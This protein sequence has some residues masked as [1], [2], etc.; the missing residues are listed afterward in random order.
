MIQLLDRSDLDDVISLG[1]YAFQYKVKPEDREKRYKQYEMHDIFGIR[2]ENQLVAKLHVIPL[3]VWVQ[4]QVVSLGGVASVATYPEYRRHGLVRQ[5]ICHALEKMKEKGQ[6][7]SM[8]HPFQIDFYRK[9]GWEVFSQYKKITIP[10]A[11]LNRM[12]HTGGSIKRISKENLN[13]DFFNYYNSRAQLY[14]GMLVRDQ[15]WWLERSIGDLSVAVYYNEHF[16]IEGYVLYKV[17]N[18]V[19]KVDEMICSSPS[20]KKGLWNFICQHDSMVTEAV[21]M[22][23]E[24]DPLPLMLQ[25][26]KIKTEIHPYFMV[27]IVDVFT[28]LQVSF[29]SNTNTLILRVKDDIV[30]SNNIAIKL[31]EEGIELVEGEEAHVELDIKGLSALCF[32]VLTAQQLYDMGELI[33]SSKAINMLQQTIHANSPHFTD[34][35]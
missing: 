8:L 35:F 31:G 7:V 30:E 12:N 17:E 15:D 33:G 6:V 23:Q 5:L 13:Q 24:E 3:K 27:R 4:G 11:D 34:F 9:F 22:L 29:S 16:T 25:N 20:A 28:F 1:E 32:G 18:K 10:K 14:N 19:I 26:P 2:V 21:I